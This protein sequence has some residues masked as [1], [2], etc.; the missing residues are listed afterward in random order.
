MAA[1]RADGAAV[2]VVVVLLSR[3]GDRIAAVGE[4]ADQAF[5]GDEGQLVAAVVVN[6]MIAIGLGDIADV[7][8]CH[9]ASFHWV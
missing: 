7:P 9:A 1:W 8:K 2:G 4:A 6:L 5:A 3:S